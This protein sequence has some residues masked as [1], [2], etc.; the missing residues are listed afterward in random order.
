MH[1]APQFH[2][3]RTVSYA[4]SRWS[5]ALLI[6][7]VAV[8]VALVFTSGLLVRSFNGLRSVDRGYEAERL[9]SLRLSANP[10]GYQG[11]DA[12]A[13]YRTLVDR[14]TA[15]AGV[16]SVGLARYFGTINSQLPEQPIGFAGTDAAVSTGATEYISPGFFAA[17]AVDAASRDCQ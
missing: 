10:N 3:A 6:T 7:Q 9:L 11:I 14:V 8:T 4:P 1:I 12:P 15:V 2:S 17:V 13:Y 16:E 5:K